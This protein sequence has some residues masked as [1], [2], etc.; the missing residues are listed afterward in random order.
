MASAPKTD[1]SLPSHRGHTGTAGRQAGQRRVLQQVAT[2]KPPRAPPRPR[3]ASGPRMQAWLRG[4]WNW[5]RLPTSISMMHHL[6]S[7]SAFLYP[8]P[9]PFSTSH[10][11]SSSAEALQRPSPR[12]LWPQGVCDRLLG[13]SGHQ[14]GSEPTAS[15]SGAAAA[16][17][18]ASRRLLLT[19][20]GLLYSVIHP[21]TTASLTHPGA[22]L[23]HSFFL[24]FF[25]PYYSLSCSPRGFVSRVCLAIVIRGRRTIRRYRVRRAATEVLLGLT[26]GEF[27]RWIVIFVRVSLGSFRNCRFVLWNLV[28]F[29]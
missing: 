3:R 24:S 5:R 20:T 19:R 15:T 12:P 4:N 21:V 17:A 7:P 18:A 8:A 16:S 22:L 10:T 28:G 14:R 9:L 6:L 11:T 1:R 27:L 23:G 2:E 26:G 29:M 13:P 25:P